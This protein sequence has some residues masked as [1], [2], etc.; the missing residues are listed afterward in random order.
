MPELLNVDEALDRILAQIQP[1]SEEIVRLDRSLGRVLATDIYSEIN[2]P[3]FANSS[4]D[5]FALRA[6]DISGAS[7]HSPVELRV[8]L[9]VPAGS[10]P[11]LTIKQGEAARIMTGAPLPD[12]ADAVIPVEDTDAVWSVAQ[13]LELPSLVQVF[14][15]VERGDYVRPAGEDI[16]RGACVLRKGNMLRPQE[17]GILAALG[18]SLVSVYRQPRVV[19]LS[20]GNELV[21]VDEPL[22]PGKIRDVNRYTLAGLVTQS[23]S[24]PV[25]LPVARDNI[26][27]VRKLFESALEE[28]PDIIMSSAGVSIGAADLIR[29]VLDELGEVNFWRVNLKPGKPLAFGK[30]QGIPFFG[31]PGNPVSAMVTFDVF[32]RPALR[33]RTGQTVDD[34]VYVNAVVGEDLRSD[35]R[36]NYLRVT[37]QHDQRQGIVATTTGTQSSSALMSMVLADG[38]LIIPEG[39][40]EVKSGTILL[41]R[42]FRYPQL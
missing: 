4:M 37:L 9:D 30:I 21:H 31:L 38:L 24:V 42:V 25:N 7:Q 34:A 6:S 36:R 22:S 12:G 20:N 10:A 5:G 23:G 14:R 28:R 33:K 19:I 15:K 29:A 41:V 17:I 27:D 18:K 26:D 1:A 3:P 2:L 40:R 13:P 11:S 39:L 16:T 35:G 8:I 32:V